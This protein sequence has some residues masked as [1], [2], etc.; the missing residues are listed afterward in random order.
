MHPEPL[1]HAIVSWTLEWCYS[2]LHGHSHNTK[3]HMEELRIAA[4]LNR[5][6]FPTEIYNVGCMHWNY[7]PVTLDEMREKTVKIYERI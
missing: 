5:K 2:H 6:G 1:L 4:E 3:E 7:Q